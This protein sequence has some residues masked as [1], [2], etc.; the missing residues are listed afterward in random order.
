MKISGEFI[1][2]EVAGETILVPVGKTALQ[3]NGIITLD[4]VG[5]LIWKGLVD[6][7]ER[8][9]IL[10]DILDTFE[11]ETQVASDDLD[12]FLKKLCDSGFLE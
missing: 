4:P 11:V 1:L 8:D 5:T 6:G 3:F 2:R 7:K 12:D 9:A 10:A